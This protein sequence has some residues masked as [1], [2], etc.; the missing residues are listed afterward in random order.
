MVTS[1][2]IG[3]VIEQLAAE[4]PD[5]TVSKIRFLESQGLI[6]PERTDSG[7]RQFNSEDVGLLRWVLRQQREH[8]LPLKVIR[9]V[10]QETGGRVPEAEES[11]DDSDVAPFREKDRPRRVVGAVSVSRE[12]LAS[13]AGVDVEIVV[14]LEKLGLVV[15]HE[16]G[17]V[18]V[19]DDEAL[20]TVRLA[21]VFVE[22][23]V[24][25]RHLRMFLVGAQREAGVIE[26]A[27]LP[28]L[29]DDDQTKREIRI[30]LEKLVEAGSRLRELMLRRSLDRFGE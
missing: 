11:M 14:Q 21:A 27:L 17:S 22:S 12:E 1:F 20:L 13:T 8:F 29:R 9:E 5:V 24:D 6:E 16:T 7:Y 19:Y 10:L 3:E 2:S 18:E 28:R 15:G 26:Q 30:E 25:A 23:G 4:F